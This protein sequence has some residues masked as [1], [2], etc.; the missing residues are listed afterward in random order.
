MRT[1]IWLARIAL[2]RGLASGQLTPEQARNIEALLDG[3]SAAARAKKAA[4]EASL[5]RLARAERWKPRDRHGRVV[6]LG[7]GRF[8]AA[9]VQILRSIDWARIIALLLALL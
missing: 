6:A 7:D 9:L 8:W 4:L 1:H 3:R 2:N 5:A